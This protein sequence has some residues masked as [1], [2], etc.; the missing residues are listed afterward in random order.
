MSGRTIRKQMF[1]QGRE[2]AWLPGA[3]AHCTK[4]LSKHRSFTLDGVRLC[5]PCRRAVFFD[6]DG[7]LQEPTEEPIELGEVRLNPP[8]P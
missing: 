6:S 3:C 4:A 8:G 1:E 7:E 2:P 5:Q